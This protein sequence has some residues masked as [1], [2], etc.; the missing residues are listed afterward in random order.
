MN[1]AVI[2]AQPTYENFAQSIDYSVRPIE[3]RR[4]YLRYF[5]LRYRVW[6]VLD[7]IGAER[8][9]PRSRLE[10][11][12]ADR[13]ATPIGVFSAHDN[14][15]IGCG[16]LVR[17]FGCEIPHTTIKLIESLLRQVAART[18]EERLVQNFRRPTGLQHP[19]DVLEGFATFNRFYK[20]LAEHFI[21]H[22][23]LGRI[24]VDPSH[25]GEGLGER[26]VSRLID[27]AEIKSID[28]LFLACLAEHEPFY[29]RNG[30]RVI[31]DTGCDRFVN[32][33]V[34][35][36]AMA[37]ILRSRARPVVEEFF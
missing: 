26:I 13:T 29:A 18:G 23:E 25:R 33:G 34:P 12:Y 7:Y 17:S 5:Q 14:K 2:T 20:V 28:V 27:L 35:A 22:A 8:D 30:F 36:I 3:S 16:R 10:V 32:I 19:Y 4:E 1:P 37:K 15:P 9:C 31:K 24:I 21:T 11:D 6:K